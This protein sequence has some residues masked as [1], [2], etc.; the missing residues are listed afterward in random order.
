MIKVVSKYQF[1]LRA[2]ENR[3]TVRRGQAVEVTEKEYKRFQGKFDL[4]ADHIKQP[5]EKSTTTK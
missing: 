2:G 3:L 5:A 4:Y 1:L